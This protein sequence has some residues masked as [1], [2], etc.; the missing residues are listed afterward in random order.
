MV[1]AAPAARLRASRARG[2]ARI[3]SAPLMGESAT[4]G[5]RPRS[6]LRVVAVRPNS[7]G[8]LVPDELRREVPDGLRPAAGAREPYRR[9]RVASRPREDRPHILR[10]GA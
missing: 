6:S 10:V 9:F 8:P 2:P 3:Q 1:A 7:V 5:G 4:G